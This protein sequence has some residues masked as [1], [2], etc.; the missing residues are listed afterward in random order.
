MRCGESARRARLTVRSAEPSIP[1][2]KTYAS[3][4][5][6]ARW[7]PRPMCRHR[8]TPPVPIQ[9]SL[10]APNQRISACDHEAWRVIPASPSQ[11]AC[12]ECSSGIP[13]ARTSRRQM[14][15]TDSHHALIV[16]KTRHRGLVDS[17]S[18]H[19][20]LRLEPA[21]HHIPDRLTFQLLYRCPARH[22]VSLIRI[23]G[24]A[25]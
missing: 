21:R 9:S 18:L 25:V 12:R 23:N 14:L 6:Y 15:C 4:L 10:A 22:L 11:R 24:F 20:P 7:G 19:A 2:R 3:S 5:A 1:R 16:L 13:A 8:S 17:H